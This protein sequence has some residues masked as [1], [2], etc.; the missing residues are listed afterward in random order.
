VSEITPKKSHV[1]LHTNK[2]SKFPNDDAQLIMKDSVGLYA[3]INEGLLK[4]TFHVRLPRTFGRP[5]VAHFSIY[6]DSEDTEKIKKAILE[7]TK[8]P[9]T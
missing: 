3:D 5:D 7:S 2:G 4:I 8:E 6:L 9:E 1:F